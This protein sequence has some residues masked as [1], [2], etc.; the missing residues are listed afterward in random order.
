[1]I[2]PEDI[3]S[4][5]AEF[6]Q[7]KRVFP[8][9]KNDE[10]ICIFFLYQLSELSTE[11]ERDTIVNMATGT[12]KRF[13]FEINKYKNSSK[14]MTSDMIRD[15][16]LTRLLQIGVEQAE[17][18]NFRHDQLLNDPMI[19]SY[20][21]SQHVS[22]YSQ[23]YFFQI[24]GPLN[25]GEFLKEI[26]HFLQGAM[27]MLGFNRTNEITLPFKHPIIPL[28]IWLRDHQIRTKA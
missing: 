6:M 4:R 22:F 9:I 27:V 12:V 14:M 21:F 19:L 17:S 16:Y 2:L 8:F 10:L 26:R 28:Y 5:I 18:R 20:C 13:D 25:E 23:D 1:M 7:G 3:H 24:Y 15:L 11:D